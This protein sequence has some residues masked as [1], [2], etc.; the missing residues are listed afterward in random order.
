MLLEQDS[1]DVLIV[2]ILGAFFEDSFD[3]MVI[4]LLKGHRILLH[5][6]ASILHLPN[7]PGLLQVFIQPA[8][9]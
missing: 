9:W 8:L 5:E 2:H 6:S 4:V 7:C 1:V 3:C